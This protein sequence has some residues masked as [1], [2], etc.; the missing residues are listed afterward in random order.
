MQ[1]PQPRPHLELS[2]ASK[3]TYLGH[4]VYAEQPGELQAQHL[5]PG[6]EGQWL[7]AA[8]RQQASLECSHGLGSLKEE[9][10]E[11]PSVSAQLQLEQDCQLVNGSDLAY[12]GKITRLS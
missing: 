10:K 3:G 7:V 9:R 11:T 12:G 4:L 1:R 5:G 6:G 2:H 8:R